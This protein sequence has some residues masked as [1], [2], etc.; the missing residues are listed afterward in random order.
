MQF[1]MGISTMRCLPPNGT[2]GLDR[3][4]VRGYRRV[5]LPPPRMIDNTLDTFLSLS[6]SSRRVC[7]TQYN[8]QVAR[9]PA[10]KRE[11]GTIYSF[12]ALAWYNQSVMENDSLLASIL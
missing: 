8:M 11:N 3:S 5:P 2:A 9:P 7:L 1:D 12:S 10:K 4:F 6:R